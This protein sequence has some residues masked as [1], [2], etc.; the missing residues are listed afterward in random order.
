MSKTIEKEPVGA[1]TENRARGSLCATI[2][3]S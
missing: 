1:G 2:G 3:L